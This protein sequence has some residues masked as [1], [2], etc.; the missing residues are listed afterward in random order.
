MPRKRNKTNKQNTTQVEL[1][2]ARDSM[3]TYKRVTDQIVRRL[4]ASLAQWPVAALAE[5]QATIKKLRD[6]QNSKPYRELRADEQGLTDEQITDV[7]KRT[8]G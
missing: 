8:K 6:E 1:E 3:E 2:Q 5:A 7:I 4:E